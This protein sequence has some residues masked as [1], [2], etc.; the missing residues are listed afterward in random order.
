MKKSE[1][2]TEKPEST[3][4]APEVPM[5]TLANCTPV[6]FLRQTNK[7]RHAAYS[8]LKDS[9]VWEIRK[10]LPQMT[11]KETAQEKKALLDEQAK[12]NLD[13]ILDALM[14]KSAEQTVNVL[15]MMCFMEPEEIQKATISEIVRPALELLNSQPVKDFLLWLVKSALTSMDG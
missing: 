9:G 14:D 4:E 6:E 7:I 13:D 3:T 11:G 12:K 2:T 8:L 1:S 10:R 5:K 15:G